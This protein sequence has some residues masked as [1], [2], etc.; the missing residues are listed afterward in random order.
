MVVQSVGPARTTHRAS[1]CWRP[2]P[3]QALHASTIPVQFSLAYYYCYCNY[4]CFNLYANIVGVNIQKVGYWCERNRK[5]S[6][7][8]NIMS[9]Y[10]KISS[11]HCSSLSLLWCLLANSVVIYMGHDTYTAASPVATHTQTL[12][13]YYCPSCELPEAP[14]HQ[15]SPPHSLFFSKKLIFCIDFIKLLWF[16]LN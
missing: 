10:Q 7:K 4:Y 2:L 3:G 16:A 9:K 12:Q 15:P 1:Q 14:A 13:Y 6:I 8:S 5:N 11:A